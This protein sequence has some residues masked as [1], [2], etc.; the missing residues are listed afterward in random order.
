MTNGNE[1]LMNKKM[2][3]TSLKKNYRTEK[4][5]LRG[6]DKIPWP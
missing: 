2:I 3:N 1:A 6:A 4:R 5:Q